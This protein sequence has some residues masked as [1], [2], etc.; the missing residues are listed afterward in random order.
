MCCSWITT[1]NVIH[2]HFFALVFPLGQHSPTVL[3][4]LNDSWVEIGKIFET[5]LCF[6]VLFPPPTH[7]SPCAFCLTRSIS[8]PLV[9]R[10]VCCRPQCLNVGGRTHRAAGVYS[11]ATPVK[12]TLPWK[13]SQSVLSKTLRKTRLTAKTSYELAVKQFHVGI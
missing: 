12:N 6:P 13:C 2:S 3:R 9:P 8:L 10:G 11:T 7:T 1:T 4:F 5:I